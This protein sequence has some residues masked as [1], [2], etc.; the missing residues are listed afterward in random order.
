M[1]LVAS[2]G[3]DWFGYVN[4]RFLKAG[5]ERGQDAVL[6]T[7]VEVRGDTFSARIPGYTPAASLFE[8][9]TE[10]ALPSGS[11]EA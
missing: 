4:V 8:G 3:A 6:G 2:N 11:V 10:R 1:V 9:V 7:V 5:I